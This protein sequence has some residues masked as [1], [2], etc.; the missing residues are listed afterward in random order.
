VYVGLASITLPARWFKDVGTNAEVRGEKLLIGTGGGISGTL[1]LH[2]LGG[3]NTLWVKLGESSGFALGFSSFDITFKQNKVLSSN[4]S[5]AMEIARFVYPASHPTNAGQPVKIGIVGHIQDD[6]DFKLTAS[7]DPAFPIELKD[8][9]I[10]N[11]RSL[12]HRHVGQAGIPGLPQEHA[13]AQRH[14]GR[15]AA[16][17]QRWQYRV[18]GRVDP[19]GRADR[20]AARS[21]RD[22]RHRYPLRVA[23]EGGE[24]RD[25]EVQLLRFRRRHQR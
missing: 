2:A 16:H 14:R 6:G 4:I 13:Q 17:L 1:G 24:R 12:E 19:P 9:F 21:R 7:T 23:P 20:A 8:V 5:A 11:I 25:A 10:Y 15:E 18:R 22:H 3:D